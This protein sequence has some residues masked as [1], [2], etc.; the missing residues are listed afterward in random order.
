MFQVTEEALAHVAYQLAHAGAPGGTV[1][2]LVPHD[3]GLALKPGPIET[4]DQTF[5]HDG[6]PVIA[7]PSALAEDLKNVVLQAEE[8]DEGT[9]LQLRECG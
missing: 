9:R 4:G 6:R 1:V 3:N 2:R 7:V 8:T 5:D